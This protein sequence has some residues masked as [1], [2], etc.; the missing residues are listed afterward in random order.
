MTTTSRTPCDLLV[1]ADV[2]VTQNDSRDIINNG[3]LAVTDGLIAAVDNAKSLHSIFAPDQT[4]E[5]GNAILMP[6]LV[7]GHT[8]LP[9]T[10]MRGIADDMPLMEWLETVIWPLER[11]F[12]PELLKLGALLGA[13]ELIRTGCTAFLNGYFQEEITGYAA[14]SCGLRTVLGEG[15]FSFPSP[16]FKDQDAYRD[17]FRA[18]HDRFK[19][20]DMVRTA[21]MPHAAYSV[22]PEDLTM[23]Y[24]LADELDVPWQTHLAESESETSLCI[25]RYGK[26]PIELVH[27]LGF[28]TERTTVHHCVDI[29]DEEIAILADSGAK[30]VHNPVSNLKLNSG[31]SPVQRLL[32]GGAI[33]GLG[34]DGAASNNQLNMFREMATAA[35]I[36]KVRD[37]SAQS[38]NAQSVLDMATRGSAQC[39]HWPELG[40]LEVGAP[41]DFVGVDLSSPNMQPMFNPISHLV[42]A[43][44]GHEVCLTACAGKILYSNGEYKTLDMPALLEEIQGVATWV[45]SRKY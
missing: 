37:D 28:L 10:L 40:R 42:Y 21:V 16:M 13:A 11:Q 6:G 2:V 30:V 3:A 7:N 14:E 9:M 36:G 33:V 24:E 20:N 34:T 44:T 43:T 1:T 15:Y 39:M 18:L 29:T 8:H 32:D 19:D 5:L 22:K 41:A 31:L 4:I 12:S 26:R 38:V 45:E 27:D 25:A 35:L 23:G 17:C